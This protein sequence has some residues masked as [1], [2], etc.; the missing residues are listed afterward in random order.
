M[1]IRS[2]IDYICVCMQWSMEN[3]ELMLDYCILILSINTWPSMLHVWLSYDIPTWGVTSLLKL[4]MIIHPFVMQKNCWI[5]I[6]VCVH[7][8][9]SLCT[10]LEMRAYYLWDCMDVVGGFLGVMIL[11]LRNHLEKIQI[12]TVFIVINLKEVLLNFLKYLDF[13]TPKPKN[14]SPILVS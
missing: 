9:T 1:H 4:Y 5:K 3:I 8:I 10:C 7:F 14:N 2:L 13:H 6:R 12:V 11:C